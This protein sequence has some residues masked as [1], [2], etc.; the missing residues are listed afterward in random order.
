LI[1]AFSGWR[2]FDS[3]RHIDGEEDMQAKRYYLHTRPGKRLLGLHQ[4]MRQISNLWTLVVAPRVASSQL[5]YI[6]DANTLLIVSSFRARQGSSP[7]G[8]GGQRADWTVAG[9]WLADFARVAGR[10]AFA[11][12]STRF[13]PG[14]LVDLHSPYTLCR[15]SRWFVVAGIFLTSASGH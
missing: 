9:G 7:E 11:G 3:T 14:R 8:C 4:K 13:P 12:C 5:V 10:R 15:F 2:M 1:A 6:L